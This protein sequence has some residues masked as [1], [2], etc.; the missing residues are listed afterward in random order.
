MYFCARIH[1]RTNEMC[2]THHFV[3]VLNAWRFWMLI[4]SQNEEEATTR[5]DDTKPVN[6]VYKS[7]RYDSQTKR[8]QTHVNSH[9]STQ[10]HLLDTLMNRSFVIL[11][12]FFHFDFNKWIRFSL[13]IYAKWSQAMNREKKTTFQD[14]RTAYRT[15]ES[16]VYRHKFSKQIVIDTAIFRFVSFVS[17]IR[18]QFINDIKRLASANIVDVLS[19][20]SEWVSIFFFQLTHSRWIE[21]QTEFSFDFYS[22]SFS[23]CSRCKF[24]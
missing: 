3:Y 21:M 10:T 11:L 18:V 16:A 19:L 9:T 7:K 17:V 20:C 13:F 14:W 8:G 24:T 2:A 6:Y 4:R 1:T 12:L 15:Q 5:S 23:F 22:I